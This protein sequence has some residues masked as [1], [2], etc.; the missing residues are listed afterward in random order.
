MSEAPTTDTPEDTDKEEDDRDFHHGDDDDP[1]PYDM[2]VIRIKA[3]GAM[4][5]V[6]SGN[7]EDTKHLLHAALEGVEKLRTGMQ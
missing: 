4:V 5:E 7:V 3:A 2:S 1:V 6:S